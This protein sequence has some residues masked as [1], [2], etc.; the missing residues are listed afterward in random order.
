[1][2]A[3]QPVL[4]NSAFATVASSNQLLL[5][6]GHFLPPYFT[7]YLPLA[8][9]HHL[10]LRT[11]ILSAALSEHG[12]FG[13]FPVPSL[14]P[15]A[16][17]SSIHTYSRNKQVRPGGALQGKLC[18]SVL[19]AS[20]ASSSPIQGRKAVVVLCSI[21]SGALKQRLKSLLASGDPYS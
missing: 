17:H 18:P 9:M 16:R 4:P 13:S 7:W 12:T 8:F 11:R 19:P 6:P 21:A 3:T 20:L 15:G 2:P 5:S 14:L 1:M 10:V